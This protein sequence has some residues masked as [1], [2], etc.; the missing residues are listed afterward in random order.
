LEQKA[1]T[2]EITEQ[3]VIRAVSDFLDT[4]ALIMAGEVGG[5]P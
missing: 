4:I 5:A 3:A 1:S 2:G